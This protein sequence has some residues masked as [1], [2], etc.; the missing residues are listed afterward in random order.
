MF[1]TREDEPS[2]QLYKALPA[3]YHM[4]LLVFAG[5]A[6]IANRIYG[7]QYSPAKIPEPDE[8]NFMLMGNCRAVSHDR[9]MERNIDRV[10]QVVIMGAGYDLRVLK[11]AG[12]KKIKVFELDQ[13]A[14]QNMKIEALKKAKI[15]HDLITYIPIDFNNESW[16]DKL[17]E[18]G[19][20]TKKKTFFLW[21]GVTPLLGE[22]IVRHTLH[23]ITSVSPKGSVI[24]LDYFSKSVVTGEG[25]WRMKQL[26]K[27]LK[28]Q[29]KNYCLVLIHPLMPVKK[30]KNYSKSV[31]SHSKT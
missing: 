28:K 15:N 14:T 7:Y 19:F 24:S 5:A 25:S 18:Y 29:V 4:S 12:G 8:A 21:E 6:L 26:N 22:E 31:V 13:P 20:D 9:N 17:L 2:V 11:Y 23:T 27:T 3:A 10:E 1:K 16:S 30:Q